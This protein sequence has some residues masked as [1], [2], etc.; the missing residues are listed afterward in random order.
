MKMNYEETIG[1]YTIWP[2]GILFSKKCLRKKYL[3]NSLSTFLATKH[4]F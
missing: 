1:K 3:F 4:K 2:S